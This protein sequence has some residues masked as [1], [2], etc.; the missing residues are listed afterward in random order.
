LIITFRRFGQLGNRLF[1]FAHLLAFAELHGKVIR[2]RAF[3]QYRSEF[4]FFQRNK[5]CTYFPESG[6][7]LKDNANT[8]LARLAG[9]AGLIP[10]VRFWDERNVVFDGL[11]SEDPRV[12]IMREE[13]IV[14][15]EG[16]KF[17]SRN[18]QSIMP[19]VR[20]VFAPRTDIGD[21]VKKR[22]QAGKNRGDL[23]VGVHIRLGDYRGTAVL[24]TPEETAREMQK[25]ESFFAP[26]KVA[27]I[28]CSQEALEP[29]LFSD[30]AVIAASEGA[31]ADLFT[32]AGCDYLL[33]V[34]STFS[35]WAS[36]YGGKPLFSLRHEKPITHM[37][38][39]EVVL[40]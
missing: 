6:G 22:I 21:I 7:V 3:A 14:I 19:R 10:T 31:T 33:G 8:T 29:S 35:G 38:Q 20:E 24:F 15:F 16:W 34:P 25:I 11:D 4:E 17:R 5:R 18:I 9:K 30:N 28:V 23:V 32:L 40:W 26:K 37:G 12:Q 13:P 36:F 39:A 27:F 2:N 1:L